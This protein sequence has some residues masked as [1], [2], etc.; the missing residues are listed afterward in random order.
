MGGGGAGGKGNRHPTDLP[1]RPRPASRW[2][3]R[4][5]IGLRWPGPLRKLCL[6]NE[7]VTETDIFGVD[8]RFCAAWWRIDRIAST[9]RWTPAAWGPAAIELSLWPWLSRSVKEPNTRM[10]NM[11]YRSQMASCRCISSVTGCTAKVAKPP[12]L[13]NRI[14]AK[15]FERARPG[16]NNPT[17]YHRSFVFL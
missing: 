6:N 7:S 16:L 1:W 9:K 5:L 4:P 11:C 12:G 13:H 8:S 14:L 3:T 2:R 15:K 17:L 10:M